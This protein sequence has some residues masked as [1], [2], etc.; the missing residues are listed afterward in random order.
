MAKPK[1]K[2]PFQPLKKNHKAAWKSHFAEKPAKRNIQASSGIIP[3]AVCTGV[4]SASAL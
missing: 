4:S 3:L 2:S 1:I